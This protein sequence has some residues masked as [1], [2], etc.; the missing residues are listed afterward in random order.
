M[1]RLERM[2][3]V[4]I[5]TARSSGASARNDIVHDH[6]TLCLMPVSDGFNLHLRLYSSEQ[7]IGQMF[8]QN[9]YVEH[10]FHFAF[11]ACH[12]KYLNEIQ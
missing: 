4:D 6:L 8:K 12:N 3:G 1:V 10:K 2:F 5:T 11:M 9:W 7:Q